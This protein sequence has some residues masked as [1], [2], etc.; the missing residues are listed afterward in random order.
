[1]KNIPVRKIK[2]VQ[3]EENSPDG[4]SIRSVQ[5]L[6][7]GK[8]LVHDLHRHEY[9]FILA[10]ETG[11]GNHKID[12]VN[13]NIDNYSVFTLRP[14]QVHQLELSADSTGF[15][16]EFT[17]N[18]YHPKDA[19]SIQLLN[20]VSSKNLC[21]LDKG[22]LKKLYAVLADI[23]S[24]YNDKQEGYQE[25]IKANL[26][27][28]FIELLRHRQNTAE[29]SA[30]ATTYGQEQLDRLIQLIEKNLSTDKKVPYYADLLN[31]SSYQ[32]NSIT[33]SLL[34]KTCSDIINEQIILEA[35]RYLLA[36]S[37]Q[38][39]QIAYHLGYEDVSYFIRFFK[40]QTGYTPD[41]FRLAF[42]S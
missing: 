7:N 35:R 16:M 12:F 36:T 37:N 4:F 26:G 2:P 39:T 40:K 29:A 38:I 13:Y 27:I 32:L 19:N 8:D 31:L 5:N 41:A 11:S 20:K 22:K 42:K 24:E 18:F 10:I 3:T 14:G 30:T 17:P 15:L 28:F 33:K 21:N 1:M 34:G 6:V 25:V 23:L 9:Y